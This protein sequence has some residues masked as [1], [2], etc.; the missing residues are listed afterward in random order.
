MTN[1]CQ[2]ATLGYPDCDQPIQVVYYP[3]QDP[4]PPVALCVEH[5]KQQARA[6]Y[7]P[8]GEYGPAEDDPPRHIT[9]AQA[10]DQHY[11]TGG[12]TP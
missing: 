6:E 12:A 5:A 1:K 9:P 7:G 11:R 4:P 2:A 10:L 8:V 3:K